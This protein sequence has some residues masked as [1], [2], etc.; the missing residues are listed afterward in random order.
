MSAAL[1]ELLRHPGVW[2]AG[3]ANRTAATRSV[4]SGNVE[5]DGWLPN[6]G[7]P[8][9][10]LTELLCESH[11]IGAFELLVPLLARLTAGGERVALVA[12][13]FVPYAPAL[14][15]RGLALAMLVVVRPRLA[16]EAHWAAEQ[17]LRSGAFASLLL[18]TQDEPT[19]RI[20]RR[21]QLAAEQGGSCAFVLRH[22]ALRADA[23]LPAGVAEA[24]AATPPNASPAV[25]RLQLAACGE[26]VRAAARDG[27]SPRLLLRV[28]KC[29]GHAP[30]APLAL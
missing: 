1:G 2:R 29:R 20:L 9:A 8:A 16:A 28:L 13:P 22:A 4:S 10:A 24:V 26:R 17:I 21:L 5:L 15:T 27:C 6:G 19:T 11:A 14:D 12:P 18:W 23:V 3:Q 30:R 7:W 25:L